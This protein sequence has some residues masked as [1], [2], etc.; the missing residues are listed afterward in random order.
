MGH[1]V[2]NLSSNGKPT[3]GYGCGL[4]NHHVK[5]GNKMVVMVDLDQNY[6]PQQQALVLLYV[7]I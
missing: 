5:E 6:S 2:L 7:I 4:L 1:G 3:K